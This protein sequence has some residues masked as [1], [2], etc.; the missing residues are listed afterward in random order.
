MGGHSNTSAYSLVYID[1]SKPEILMDAEWAS[2]I[3]GSKEE[4]MDQGELEAL[5]VTLPNDLAQYVVDD[6]N[7]FQEEIM[8]WDRD[9]LA[10]NS[11]PM[12]PNT[13]VL[14]MEQSLTAQ[15]TSEPSDVQVLKLKSSKVHSYDDRHFQVVEEKLTYV[16]NHA[17][18]SL[19]MTVNAVQRVEIVIKEKGPQT[20]VLTALERIIDNYCA[21]HQQKYTEEIKDGKPGAQ[22]PKTELLP[23][24]D[25]KLESFVYYLLRNDETNNMPLVE[26]AVLEQ[27]SF[28]GLEMNSQSMSSFRAA[29]DV[30]LTQRR[31]KHPHEAAALRHW[32]QAYHFFRRSVHCF[33]HGLKS[34]MDNKHS[35]A[36]DLY[37]EAFN[38]TTK[39]AAVPVSVR[40]AF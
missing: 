34:H 27:F 7:Q 30:I 28:P 39:A 1:T 21:T 31:A 3:G 11:S 25:Y 24:K 18:L 16:N 38:Y 12:K 23:C 37:T 40:K 9:Q 13:E 15:A 26:L 6:N 4:R 29:A 8:Q 14:D 35:Q 5:A 19:E 20:A 33:I 10:Q 22:P 36:L 32:H 2:C 17:K